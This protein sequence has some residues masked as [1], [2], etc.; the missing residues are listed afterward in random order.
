MNLKLECVLG[1]KLVCNEFGQNFPAVDPAE[2]PERTGHAHMEREPAHN[3][4]G[5]CEEQRTEE[6]VY[7]TITIVI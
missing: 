6:E 2:I 7:G 1:D 4:W 3:G 5:E